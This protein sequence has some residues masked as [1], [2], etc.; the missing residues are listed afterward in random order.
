MREYIE[1]ERGRFDV[2]LCRYQGL[3]GDGTPL[4]IEVAY[5]SADSYV[6]TDD[7]DEHDS[8]AIEDFAEEYEL[9]PCDPDTF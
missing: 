5:S 3:K 2:A 7:A 1:V 8:K 4:Y 6:V 9:T